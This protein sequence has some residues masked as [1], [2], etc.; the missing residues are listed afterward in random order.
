VPPYHYVFSVLAGYWMKIV[1]VGLFQARVFYLSLGLLAAPFIFLIARRLYGTSVAIVA[2]V[3]A[4]TIPLAHN[5]ARPDMFVVTAF[6]AGFYCLLVGRDSQRLRFH[7]LAGLLTAFGIE[8][9]LYAVRFV[10][11]LGL[12]YVFDYVRLINKER[13]WVWDRALFSYVLGIVTF[14]GYFLVAHFLVL[15]GTTL[16]TMTNI[17]SN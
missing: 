14:G 3:L 8:G 9:H 16:A 11:T 10:I 4:I 5:Y 13:R 7:Y 15:P 2:L 17:Y 6:S 1:G 12:V